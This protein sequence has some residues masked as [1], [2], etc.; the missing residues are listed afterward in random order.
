[1]DTIRDDEIKMCSN[2]LGIEKPENVIS[3]IHSELLRIEYD[4][5]I[6]EKREIT[7]QVRDSKQKLIVETII[8][9]LMKKQI[10]LSEENKN[11]D[12]FISIRIGEGSEKDEQPDSIVNLENFDFDNEKTKLVSRCNATLIGNA[13]IR[14]LLLIEDSEEERKTSQT[15]YDNTIFML[16]R[17]LVGV[18]EKI[19]E[20]ENSLLG[21]F[22][23][24]ELEEFYEEEE[25]LRE[26]LEEYQRKSEREESYNLYKSSKRKERIS[27]LFQKEEKLQAIKY[28]VT[29]K[30]ERLLR[31]I[32][33][34]GKEVSVFEEEKLPENSTDGDN[35]DINKYEIR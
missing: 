5:R 18:N 17:K 22:R 14:D 33:M 27:G 4:E 15:K 23:S 1:M 30:K 9:L 8:D 3:I 2:A 7:I 12:R 32:N 28:I 20:Y 6:P 16:Q 21:I 24:D 26:E 11:I 29:G 13:K 35:I 19:Q 34:E 10:Q 31:G 25:S